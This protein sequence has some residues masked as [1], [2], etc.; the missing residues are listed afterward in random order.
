MAPLGQDQVRRRPVHSPSLTFHGVFIGLLCILNVEDFSHLLNNLST[1]MGGQ[2]VGGWW[3][4]VEADLP[5]VLGDGK[6]LVV[7]SLREQITNQ[8]E[9]EFSSKKQGKQPNPA[10]GF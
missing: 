2:S 6:K 5:T 4:C 1:K 8:R 7:L 10:S 3:K 9:N